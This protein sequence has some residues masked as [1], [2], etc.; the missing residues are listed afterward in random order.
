MERKGDGL[1]KW[2]TFSSVHPFPVFLC[3]PFPWVSLF[4]CTKHAYLRCFSSASKPHHHKRM[5]HHLSFCV[6]LLWVYNN[7]KKQKMSF[8]VFLSLV[9]SLIYVFFLSLTFDLHVCK[10][11]VF[12]ALSLTKWYPSS[13]SLFPGNSLFHSLFAGRRGAADEASNRERGEEKKEK[14]SECKPRH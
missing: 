3:C 11:K 9:T 13:L 6:C 14:M 12:S 4:V 1:E 10:D 5:I 8:F 7:R 2:C